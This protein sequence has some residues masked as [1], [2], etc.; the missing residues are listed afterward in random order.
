MNRPRSFTKDKNERII[1]YI[2]SFRGQQSHYSLKDSK[3]VYLPEDLNLSK[4]HAMYL[5]SHLNPVQEK[6]IGK[7]VELGILHFRN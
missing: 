1:N 4:M 7:L 3:K 6:F 2:R 5:E